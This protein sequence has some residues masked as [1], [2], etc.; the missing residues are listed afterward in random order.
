MGGRS[1]LGGL[2]MDRRLKHWEMAL[3]LGVLAAAILGSW[4]GWEQQALA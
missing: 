4:L 2:I 1:A 3:I